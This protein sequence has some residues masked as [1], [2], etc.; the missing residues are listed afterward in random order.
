MS[1]DSMRAE[2]ALAAFLGFAMGD[3]LGATVEFMT[4]D[5]IA[6]EY[7]VHRD[8]VGGGWLHL[9]PGRVTDD[10]E[11]ALAVGRSLLRV[12]GLDLVDLCDEFVRWLRSGPI[13]VGHTCRRGIRRYINNG[14]VAGPFNEGDAGNGAA[15]RVLPVAL[16]NLDTPAR[17]AEWAAAQGHIT[18]HHPL[19]D[20]ACIALVDM[21]RVL[22][23][24]DDRAAAFAAAR[25]RADALV[26]QHHRFVFTPYRGLSTA[27]VVDTIQTAFHGFFTTGS[28]EDCIVTTVNLG[29]DADTTGAIAGMLAGALYGPEQLPARWLEALDAE[30]T[31]EIRAMVPRLLA[32]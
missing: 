17:G 9:R 31:A 22:I 6:V 8:I 2:R 16:A 18:H 10:T 7:G 25:R 3:A 32:L 29:G 13:D 20:G 1:S 15:M 23:T 4:R 12:G 27:Y 11:M 5:E 28:L 14:T 19:S 30:V 24:E 26:E 21:L